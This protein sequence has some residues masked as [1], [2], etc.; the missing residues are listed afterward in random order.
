VNAA[1]QHVASKSSRDASGKGEQHGDVVVSEI[2]AFVAA[3]DRPLPQP[4]LPAA[5]VG[6][7]AWR[8]KQWA[9]EQ[10]RL[11]NARVGEW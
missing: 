11:A 1:P 10:R 4:Q 3:L 7:F 6:S 8:K 9:A 2:I 5:P